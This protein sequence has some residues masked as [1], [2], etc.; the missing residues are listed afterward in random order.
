MDHSPNCERRLFNTTC[1]C[2][3]AEREVRERENDSLMGPDGVMPLASERSRALATKIAEA[4]EAELHRGITLP[5]TEAVKE[6]LNKLV[7]QGL[8]SEEA[9]SVLLRRIAG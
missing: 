2:D 8:T 7:S 5:V 3:A 9:E 6:A 4:A 1:T